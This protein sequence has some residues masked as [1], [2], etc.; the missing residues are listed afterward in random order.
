MLTPADVYFGRARDL[1]ANRK[2]VLTNAY[3][4]PPE[5]VPR[6]RAQPVALPEAVFINP[7]RIEAEQ[8]GG[9]R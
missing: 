2:K 7:P 5:R 4:D 1:L 3:R 8:P 6:G 9:A